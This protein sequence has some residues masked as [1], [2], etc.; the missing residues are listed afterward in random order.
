MATLLPPEV[1]LGPIIESVRLRCALGIRFRDTATNQIVGSGLRVTATPTGAPVGTE[2]VSAR[3]NGSG[4]WTFH[5]LRDLRT[6]E[7]GTEEF[8]ERG[9]PLGPPVFRIEVQ[10]EEGRFL[11]CA[12][13]AAAS[14]NG[15]L[16][17]TLH[18]SPPWP[19]NE[20]PLFSAPS[21]PVP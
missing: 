8:R 2:R 12:F 4:V 11:P 18:P 19:W 14:S 7:L 5:G 20:V 13:D 15:P 16:Q 21:R 9:S 10:D 6:F 1:K 17:F 3:V